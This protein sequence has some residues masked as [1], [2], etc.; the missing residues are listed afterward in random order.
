MLS[1]NDVT[2]GNRGGKHLS[3]ALQ[4]FPRVN[5]FYAVKCNPNPAII[6]MLAALGAGFDC[7]SEAEVELVL[8]AG[9]T[10]EQIIYAHPCKPPNQVINMPG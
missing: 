1:K 8:S 3:S 2:L 4:A 7:A 10:Q 5:P 9:V 6:A